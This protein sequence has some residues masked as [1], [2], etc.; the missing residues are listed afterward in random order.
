AHVFSGGMKT[1][2][3]RRLNRLPASE[4][5][6]LRAAA[7][8][9][10]QLDLVLLQAV[11]P[12]ADLEKWL[13]ICE[14]ASVLGFQ[15]SYWRFSHDKLREGVLADLTAEQHV[16]L[17]ERIALA[18]E[19]CYPDSPTQAAALAGHWGAAGNLLKEARYCTIAGEQAAEAGAHQE[20]I[21]LLG[22]AD[23]L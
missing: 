10:R 19:S 22:R 8:A 18:I 7:V 23:S 14:D 12:Q 20:A 21:R 5:P 9:G 11:E 16:A 2:V 4:Q 15:D 6:L 3:Q 13:S 1:V 17:N